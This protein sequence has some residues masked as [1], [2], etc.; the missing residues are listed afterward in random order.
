MQIANCLLSDAK[1]LAKLWSEFRQNVHHESFAIACIHTACARQRCPRALR[2]FLYGPT[3][4]RWSKTKLYSKLLHNH[5]SGGNSITPSRL[6]LATTTAGRRNALLAHILGRLSL[7]CLSDR[8]LELLDIIDKTG[9]SGSRRPKT[10]CAA[11]IFMVA[12][13]AGK[14]VS[15]G[16]VASAAGLAGATVVACVQVCGHLCDGFKPQ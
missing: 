10:V 14:P 16:A 2:A 6:K 3:D 7:S 12:A 8:C 15:I 13:A 1:R 9:A 4:S 11:A 5:L